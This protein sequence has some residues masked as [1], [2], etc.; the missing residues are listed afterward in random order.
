MNQQQSF[1]FIDPDFHQEKANQYELTIRIGPEQWSYLVCDKERKALVLADELTCHPETALEQALQQEGQL[2]H[3]AYSK[4]RIVVVGASVVTLPDELHSDSALEIQRNW[5]GAGEQ[6]MYQNRVNDES[7]HYFFTLPPD[8]EKL[9][10]THFPEAVHLSYPRMALEI[11]GLQKEDVIFDFSLK[12]VHISIFHK[13]QVLFQKQFDLADAEEL[14][15]YL[16]LLTHQFGIS[17]KEKTARIAGIIHEN[18][19][20]YTTLQDHFSQMELLPVETE[21]ETIFTHMPLHYYKTLMVAST[22]E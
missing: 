13:Q 7:L 17:F 12:T 20:F 15:Y 6:R 19:A 3:L 1:L 2:L 5:L 10:T 16:H 11:A 8:L 4:V 9:L 21:P 18:D 14:N 22:C